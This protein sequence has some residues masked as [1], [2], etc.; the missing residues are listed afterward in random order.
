[1]NQ[2]ILRNLAF[3]ALMFFV[4]WTVADYMSGS[5][6]GPQATALGYSDFNAKVDA[7]EVD[8]VVIIQ[9]NIRGTL[10]DGTEFTT[11]A[12]DA[13]NSDRDLY[14]RLADKGIH[15]SAENRAAVVADSAYLA[16]SNRASDRLLVLH[17]A[18]VPDG[19]RTHDEFWQVTCAPDGERQE[20]GDVR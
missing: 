18:A 3:Y 12:P 16:H 14:K 15:I 4:V 6:Q 2:S 9:N 13:P 10:T 11:I 19:R 7:G 1:M 20:K 17:H 8:K 5:H